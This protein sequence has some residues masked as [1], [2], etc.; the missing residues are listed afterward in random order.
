MSM[1]DILQVIGSF[2]FPIAMCLMFWQFISK[3]LNQITKSLDSNTQAINRL[4][5]IMG[6]EEEVM[7][8]DKKQ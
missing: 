4:A 8:R 2:G 6:Q 5:I 3:S 1:A 7:M